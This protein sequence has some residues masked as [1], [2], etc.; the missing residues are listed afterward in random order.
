MDFESGRNPAKY[1]SESDSKSSFSRT[2][3]PP[4]QPRRPSPPF[5]RLARV[6]VLVDADVT[7]VDV[8]VD[9]RRESSIRVVVAI[10]V[11]HV[12]VTVDR[13]RTTVARRP[14]PRGRA[15]AVFPSAR[16]AN[17]VVFDV[18]TVRA[19][20]R[21]SMTTTKR[22]TT[23]NSSRSVTERRANANAAPT[24]GR[25][26]IHARHGCMH[27]LIMDACIPR[28]CVCSPCVFSVCVLC[29]CLVVVAR[30]G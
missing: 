1:S 11:V 13:A 4:L 14:R 17:V 27:V 26:W 7:D 9:A 10:V 15:A 30:H 8:D 24:R 18:A 6:L 16:P 25:S 2:R 19:S 20:A 22:T 5:G 3:R 29:V 23:T 21:A 28:L 12:G